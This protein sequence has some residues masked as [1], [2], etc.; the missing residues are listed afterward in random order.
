MTTALRLLADQQQA[1]DVAQS[2]FLRAY[3]HFEMLSQSASAGG[4][5]K[6]VTRNECLNHLTRYRKRWRLFSDYPQ[7]E[8]DGPELPVEAVFDQTWLDGMDDA[9]REAHVERALAALPQALR[10]PLVL[11]Y[12]EDLPYA[13]IAQ[14][15]DYSLAKVKT[16]IHRARLLLAQQLGPKGRELYSS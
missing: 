16:N 15:L 11:F 14:Q 3:T 7:T 2:V 13:E 8:H 10:V 1:Q 5:L 12:F 6:T 4:W 9:R